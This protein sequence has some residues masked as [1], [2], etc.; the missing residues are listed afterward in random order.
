MQL[1]EAG[2]D[3]FPGRRTKDEPLPARVRSKDAPPTYWDRNAGFTTPDGGACA[4]EFEGLFARWKGKGRGAQVEE[5]AVG[6]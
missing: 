5:Q 2:I 1:S 4:Y 3:I 6:W